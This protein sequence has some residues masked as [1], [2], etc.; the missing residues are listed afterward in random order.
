MK[1]I[2]FLF[3]IVVSLIFIFVVCT[4]YDLNRNKFF[5]F[6]SDVEKYK[7]LGTKSYN[8]K[9]WKVN[10]ES[11]KEM[12]YSYLKEKKYIIEASY[13]NSIYFPSFQNEIK[14]VLEIGNINGKKSYLVI[15]YENCFQLV[16]YDSDKLKYMFYYEYYKR[17]NNLKCDFTYDPYTVRIFSW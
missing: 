5:Y 6:G 17:K 15:D 1:N 4:I 8:E 3:I 13:D 10:K 9:E 12:L 7:V 11:R 14:S 2:K 16:P